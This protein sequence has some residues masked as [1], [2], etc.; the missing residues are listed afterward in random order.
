MATSGIVTPEAVVLE[1][2]TAGFASRALAGGIDLAVQLVLLM[3]VFF[4]VGIFATSGLDLGGVGAALVYILLFLVVFGYPTAMETLWRGRTLGKAALGLRV[5]TVE[6]APVRFRHAAIR[7]ILALVDW[8]STEAA[9][10][11]ISIL[12]TK[13]N[14]RLGDLVAG[15]IVLRERTA[16]KAPMAIQFTAPPGLENYTATLATSSLGHDDYGSIRSFLLRAPA[17][18][19]A[20]RFDLGARIAAPLVERLRTTPPPGV[21]PELFLVCVAA[22]YQRRMAGAAAGA[23][24]AATG[25]RSVWAGTGRTV[26]WGPEHAPVARSAAVAADEDDAFV[27]PG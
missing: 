19:P 1:F 24:A 4:G 18:P 6:G 11:T 5:V 22:A 2:E 15:T 17:L 16:T 20:I 9:V 26:A 21:N 13:R 14:Q 7:A 27:A 3:G 8:Y 23:Q 12:V 10:G 25:F